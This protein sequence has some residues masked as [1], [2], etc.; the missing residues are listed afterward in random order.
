MG[1]GTQQEHSGP[2]RGRKKIGSI[3]VHTLF[4]KAAEG[5]GP[6]RGTLIPFGSGYWTEDKTPDSQGYMTLGIQLVV[7]RTSRASGDLVSL[8]PLSHQP[9][10]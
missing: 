7:Q 9:S 2:P 4:L 8:G 3:S 10:V 6:Q 5:L 1:S